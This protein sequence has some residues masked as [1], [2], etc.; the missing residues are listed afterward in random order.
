MDVLDKNPT[1]ST[2][3]KAADATFQWDH[4]NVDWNCATPDNFWE[5]ADTVRDRTLPYAHQLFSYLATADKASLDFVLTQYRY[6]TTYYIPDLALLVARLANERLRSFLADILRDELG[7]GEADQAHP[8]LYD[9]FLN[10]IGV[11]DSTI[12]SSAMKSNI[13]LLNQ[14]RD[15]LVDPRN[16]DAFAVGLRGMGGE[17]ICQVYLAQLHEQLLK[18]PYISKN[19]QGID[20]VFWDIHIG[21]HDLEHT[22]KTRALIN[23]EF[24]IKEGADLLG[25]GRGYAASMQSWQ[26]FWEN[27]FDAV[28][29]QQT[30]VPRTPIS[31]TVTM[32]VIH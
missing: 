7:L 23:E 25:L 28:K 15:Q 30:D 12:Q 20:W 21:E 2:S 14:A 4:F 11:A 5:L 13:D 9:D 8:K 27:I 17:C 31:S 18:N 22:R 26:M 16:S 32:K 1:E 6:F 3:P 19:F 10:S 24:V 29:K